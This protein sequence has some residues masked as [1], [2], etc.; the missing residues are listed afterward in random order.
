MFTIRLMLSV[1]VFC[2][3]GCRSGEIACPKIKG[4]KL[5]KTN[6]NYGHHQYY[7]SASLRPAP[8]H[9]EESSQTKTSK[10][11]KKN[12]LKVVSHVSVEEWDCPRPGKTKYMPRAV[13]NNIRK[14]M[15]KIQS[16]Q[17]Q[18]NQSDSLRN[19]NR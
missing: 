6:P 9:H 17:L 10:A 18:T 19:V 11:T 14:N 16:P 3:I 12:N 7:A 13:R 2:F 8:E 5:K 15:R 4:A 1:L